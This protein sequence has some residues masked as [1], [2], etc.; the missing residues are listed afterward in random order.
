MTNGKCPMGNRK[1]FAFLSCG[2]DTSSVF[3]DSSTKALSNTTPFR[4]LMIFFCLALAS[5][6]S[7]V[8]PQ[9]VEDLVNIKFQAD[10]RVFAVMAAANAAGFDLDAADVDHN[11]VRKLVRERALSSSPELRD[12]LREFYAAHHTGQEDSLEQA[13]YVSLALFLKGPPDFTLATKPPELPPEVRPLAGFE[14]LVAGLW[15]QAGLDRL[16]EQVRPEY[17]RELEIYRPLLQT[18]IIQTLRYLR[19]DPRVALD[20]KVVFIPDLLN[21]YG[22]VNARNLEND[23]VV[24]VGPSRSD[25]RP[26][27]SLRHEYLHF[28]IDPMLAKY[29]NDLPDP[30]PYLKRAHEQPRVRRSY[31]ND[32]LVLVTESLLQMVELRLD[33]VAEG[34][35]AR[36]VID[37]Y[38]QGLVLA[39]YF[40]KELGTFEKRQDSLQEFFPIMIL[41]IERGRDTDIAQLRK[42]VESG[43][44]SGAP[45][46]GAGPVRSPEI[47]AWL[48]QA[49]QL[50]AA[51]EFDKASPLL[52]R[53]LEVDPLNAPALFGLAQIA[54]R[55]QEFDRALE[56]YEKAEANSGSD[57]WI[58]AW[59]LVRRGNIYRFLGEPEKAKAEWSRVLQLQGDLRGAAEAAKKS[60]NQRDP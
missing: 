44:K 41:G 3:M 17:I 57:E 27:R 32:F 19:T 16:W 12:R 54:A 5:S 24:L 42:E 13:N 1:F 26:M 34:S 45:G 20:R 4:R 48:S 6:P 31:E 29:V 58:A 36:K 15:R 7:F 9:V 33:R 2:S 35:A 50:L 23:Y 59:S 18:M 53:V 39:P 49:N 46:A 55:A 60:L 30:Q 14:S 47:R 21:G 10:V 22:V 52:E 28:L 25:E 56:L 37:A 40:R 11:P 38:E 43:E 8:F 51:E